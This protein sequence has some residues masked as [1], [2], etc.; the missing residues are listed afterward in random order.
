MI[1]DKSIF[2]HNVYYMLSYA[3]QDLQ[4]DDEDDLAGESFEHLHDLLAA[5]LAKG[6][7]RQIKQGLHCEYRSYIEDLPA[8][9]GKINLPGT[10]RNRLSCKHTLRCEHDELSENNLLNQVIKTTGM[11]LL[12]H[13]NVCL[14]RHSALKKCLL[15]LSDVNEV[16][17]TS[18]RW[19]D[20]RFTRNTR[21]YRTL[22]SICHL[23]LQG[24]ILTN[25]HGEIHLMTYIKPDYMERLFEKFILNYYNV[26]CSPIKASSTQIKWALD[27]D[28]SSTLLPT[29]QS[30]IMLNYKNQVL[31][32]DAKYYTHSTQKNWDKHTIVSA[33]LYQIFTY[34]KNKQAEL[35]QSGGSRQVSGMLLYARTDEDIQPDG[36]Y[37]MSGNQISVTTLDLNYPFE[38]LSAQ[39]NSIAATH[40]ETVWI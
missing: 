36:V 2:I 3:F 39:L 31:I 11:I 30:D 27:D 14:Q 8:L 29:M 20:I 18:I 5:L 34:V 12:R 22:L 13:G 17:P 25:E 16:E 28:S 24:M 10:I 38:Q 4:S 19:S 37:Q 32:I 21:S 33:N 26:E 1:K 6:I 23:I 7:A 9:H 15:Y 40:F 35:N